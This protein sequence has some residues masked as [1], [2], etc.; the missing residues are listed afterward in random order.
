MVVRYNHKKLINTLRDFYSA[1]GINI[2]VLDADFNTIANLEDAH[3]IYCCYIKSSRNGKRACA[4]SDNTL[5]N[6]CRQSRSPEMHICHAGLL[7]IAMP[8]IHN[9]TIIAY[10]IMGQMRVATVFRDLAP[11]IDKLGLSIQALSDIYEKQPCYDKTRTQA[12]ANLAVMLTK[13]ILLENIL[14]PNISKTIDTAEQFINNNLQK[15]L[16]IQDISKGTNISKNIL[17]KDF[18][19]CYNC[20]VKEYINNKRI[21]KSV[22]LLTNTELS[23]EEISQAIGFSS[24]AYFSKLFKLQK[25]IPPLKYRKT[26]KL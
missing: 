5:L 20:T 22:E 15:E 4:H 2:S 12:I 3:N 14:T 16:T 26:T 23:I 6:K 17:Y 25:G 8:V 1:T 21:E 9:D 18:H 7:D 19:T 24:A 11:H 13:Y 10:V